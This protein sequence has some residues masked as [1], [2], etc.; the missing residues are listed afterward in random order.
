VRSP[1]QAQSPDHQRAGAKGCPLNEL[2]TR[3]LQSNT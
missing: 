2:A 3:Q 1:R